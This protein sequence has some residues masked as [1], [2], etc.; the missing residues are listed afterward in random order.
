[1]ASWMESLPQA[2]S[3]EGIVRIL[4]FRSCSPRTFIILPAARH[5]ETIDERLAEMLDGPWCRH[6]ERYTGD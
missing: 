2:L 1:M 4:R 5:A 6:F 3:F